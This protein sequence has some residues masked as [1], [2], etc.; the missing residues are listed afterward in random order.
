MHAIGTSARPDLPLAAIVGSGALGMAMA[1]RFAL[2]HRV[3]LVDVDGAKAEM[4]AETLRGEGCDAAAMACDI[5]SRDAVGALAGE[6]ASR[7]GLGALV[8]VA[9]LS[10]SQA[11]YRSIMRVNLMGAALVAE[12]LLLHANPGAAAILIASLAAHSYRPSKEAQTVL[13]HPS[14][15]DLAERLAEVIGELATPPMAYTHSKF[16]L[17][18]Y[19][20][21][22]ATAWGQRDA[23]IVSLSP[24]MIATPMGAIE[25]ANSPHK[26]A[27]FEKTPLRRECTM[28]EI[29]D[30]AEF[31]ASPRA[32][33]ISGTD[34]LVDGGLAAALS[35][36]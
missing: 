28:L 33:F 23:R 11:D 34:I 36:S 20:R 24:G 21:S 35:V 29:A 16:G 25:F 32:S 14:R 18:M 4:H 13:A 8:Q 5:T 17:L 15:D 2:S 27:M 6:V 31:L 9:G 7:G 30:A 19:A 26:R 3:L 12:A 1:R 22:Q 10:P